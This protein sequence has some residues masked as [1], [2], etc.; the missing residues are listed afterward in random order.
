MNVHAFP[1][2]HTSD[3]QALLSAIEKAR[4]ELASL[5]ARVFPA[6]CFNIEAQA[7]SGLA[8][9]EYARRIHEISA[10]LLTEATVIAAGLSEQDVSEVQFRDLRSRE[11]L[12]DVLTDASEW[13]EAIRGEA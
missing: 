9:I 1:T 6:S 4:D 5:A 2:T 10:D 3:K 12:D 8:F 7:E 11:S 13:C